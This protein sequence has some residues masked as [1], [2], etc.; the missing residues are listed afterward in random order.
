[1]ETDRTE[2][3][4]GFNGQ[5]FEKEDDNQYADELVSIRLAA[6]AATRWCTAACTTANAIELDAHAGAFPDNR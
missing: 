5:L 2:A 6:K 4:A 1:M 3:A